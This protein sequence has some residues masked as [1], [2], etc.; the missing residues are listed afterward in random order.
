MVSGS[1]PAKNNQPSNS[2]HLHRLKSLPGRRVFPVVGKR[3][4]GPFYLKVRPC[5]PDKTEFR[6]ALPEKETNHVG[7]H[8]A[9]RGN[10]Q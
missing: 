10:H 8:R 6:F 9:Y 4:Y 2:M 5:A 3:L 1:W 7:I